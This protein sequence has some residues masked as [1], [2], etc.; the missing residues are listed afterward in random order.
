VFFK[1]KQVCPCPSG[2]SYSNLDFQ[3]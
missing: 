1:V 3:V 2:P